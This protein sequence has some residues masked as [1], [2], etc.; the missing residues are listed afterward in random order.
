VVVLVQEL[1]GNGI[2]IQGFT[3][4]VGTS[5]TYGHGFIKSFLAATTYYEL[6]KL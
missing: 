4:L 3:A 2:L 1:V 5:T 6:K